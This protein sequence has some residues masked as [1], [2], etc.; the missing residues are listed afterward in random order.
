MFEYHSWLKVMIIIE[1]LFF[2]AFYLKRL[3]TFH[4]I[5]SV[6]DFSNLKLRKW[7]GLKWLPVY[8]LWIDD[9]DKIA[10]FV[11]FWLFFT[12]TYL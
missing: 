12:E 9:I 2:I 5:L 8:E 3:R 7:R 10:D 1:G 4:F 6:F 11:L